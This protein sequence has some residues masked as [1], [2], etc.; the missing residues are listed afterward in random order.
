MIEILPEY[1]FFRPSVSCLPTP[2]AV[3][4]A[5]WMSIWAATASN[6]SMPFRSHSKLGFGFICNVLYT[7]KNHENQ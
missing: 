3:R 7:R 1:T 6:R 5:S 2:V 4:L